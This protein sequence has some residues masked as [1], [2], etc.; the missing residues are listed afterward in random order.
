MYREERQSNLLTCV[1]LKTEIRSCH[2]TELVP[3]G[4]TLLF[5]VVVERGESFVD[6]VIREVKEETGLIISPNP[7]SVIKNSGMTTRIRYVSLFFK[8]E[9]FLLVLSSPQTGKVWWEDFE[10]IFHLKNLTPDICLML[11]VF[12]EEDLSEFFY[13]KITETTVFNLKYKK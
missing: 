7:N 5:L 9:H 13:Y 10:K 3:T 1:W 2:K 11:C 6:A 8:T 4:R 12:L